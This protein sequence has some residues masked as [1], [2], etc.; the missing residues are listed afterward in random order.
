MDTFNEKI[1]K[2]CKENNIPII[3]YDE[4]K[5]NKPAIGEGS[6]GK[7]YSGYFNNRKIAL[8]KMKFEKIEDEFI[9]EILNEIKTMS[10]ASEVTQSVPKF[11]GLWKGKKS[12]GHVIDFIDGKSLSKLI[13]T[14]SK[15]EKISVMIQ[16]CEILK[17]IHSKNMIHRDI[18]PENIIIAEGLKVFLIDFGVCRIAKRVITMTTKPKGTPHYNAPETVDVVECDDDYAFGISTKADIWS[19]GIIISE[20]FSGEVPWSSVAK[21]EH[22]I[23][24]LIIQQRD[25]PIPPNIDPE[26]KDIITDCVN[27][28][29][30]ERPTAEEVILKFSQIK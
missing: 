17:A 4:L 25:F 9:L 10:I 5:K 23:N 27:Y 14:L 16:L 26:I 13:N 20:L 30:D 29:I 1:E 8:K 28:Q 21:N 2:V 12:V 18:K 19:L 6:Y 24:C 11:Y 3:N 15:K 7:V 22:H